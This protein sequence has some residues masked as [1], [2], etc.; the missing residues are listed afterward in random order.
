MIGTGGRD[1]WQGPLAGTVGRDSWRKIG[2]R[3]VGRTVRH[4]IRRYAVDS[5]VYRL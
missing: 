2:G 5:C 3:T 1:S 4:R